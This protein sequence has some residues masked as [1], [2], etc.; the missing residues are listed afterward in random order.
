MKRSLMIVNAGTRL[1]KIDWQNMMFRILRRR[2]NI[3][4][5]LRQS[6]AV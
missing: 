5:E 6:K 1:C 4:E 3:G 2:L